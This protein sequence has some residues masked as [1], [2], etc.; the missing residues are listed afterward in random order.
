MFTFRG[1]AHRFFM[2]IKK[3]EPKQYTKIKEVQEM[4]AI[5][6]F[7]RTLENSL[8]HKMKYQ[9]MKEQQASGSIPLLVTTIPW[10]LFIFS[11]PLLEV[12]F[13]N[14]NLWIPFVLIYVTL[15]LGG[16][17]LHFHERAW[18]KVHVEIIEDVLSERN[19]QHL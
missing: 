8:L 3:S 6:M 1:D 16:I 11:K 13:G 14:F 7:Y 17:Y 19:Q 10:L 9:M 15:L 4:T 12:L 5:I 2:K 18:A